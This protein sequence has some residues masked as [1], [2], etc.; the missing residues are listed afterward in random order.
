M[1]GCD[2]ELRDQ[3]PIWIDRDKDRYMPSMRIKIQR[4]Q[5]VVVGGYSFSCSQQG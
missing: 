4:T 2:K 3:N 5:K 1:E